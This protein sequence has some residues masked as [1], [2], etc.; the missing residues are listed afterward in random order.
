MQE[1]PPTQAQ[2]QL[3]LSGLSLQDHS[4]LQNLSL[5]FLTSNNRWTNGFCHLTSPLPP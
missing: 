2:K 4:M 3:V 1:T 5:L